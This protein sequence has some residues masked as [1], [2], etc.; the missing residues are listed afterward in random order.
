MYLNIFEFCLMW[1]DECIAFVAKHWADVENG[2]VRVEVY[3]LAECLGL[4]Y[5]Y[6]PS[7][8]YEN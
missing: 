1:T 6:G 8:P 3:L 4:L 2:H 7:V 5:E